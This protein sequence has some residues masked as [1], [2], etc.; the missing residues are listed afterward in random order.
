MNDYY[1]AYVF[2]V[3]CVQ[4]FQVPLTQGLGIPVDFS[5]G[6]PTVLPQMIS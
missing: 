4:E 6:E 2:S 1:R 3:R 5:G